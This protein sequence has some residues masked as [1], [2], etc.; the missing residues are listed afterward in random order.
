MRLLSY[1]YG[2][3][4]AESVPTAIEDVKPSQTELSSSESEPSSES[5]NSPAP[6]QSPV[7][8]PTSI[9][10]PLVSTR[11]AISSPNLTRTFSS[12]STPGKKRRFSFRPF[13]TASVHPDGEKHILSTIEE[14]D[15]REQASAAFAKRF[16]KPLS[17]NSDKRAKESAVVVRNLILGPNTAAPK[18]TASVARP[19]LNKIKSQLIQPKA[20]N[21]LIA[22]L[23]AMPVGST[24][25]QNGSKI[26]Y[27]TQPIHAVC[28]E[29]TEEEEHSLYFA[30]LD[31]DTQSVPVM[32]SSPSSMDKLANL[33]NDM[34][35]VSLVTS[36]DLG[37][38]Q[39]GNGPGLLAGAVPTAETVINGI[40]QITPQ[41]LA[42]G[43]A[44]GKAILPDHAGKSSLC[45]LNVSLTIQ[46]GVHPPTDRISVLTCQYGSQISYHF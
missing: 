37:L 18:V 2:S 16:T 6:S 26:A 5:S 28:L 3:P 32:A 44:T 23:R 19:Q 40:Q 30:H 15:K 35:I 43:F 7:V 38:G 25:S 9:P 1:L 42:L 36:P 46:T 11:F 8:P 39:P 29:H 13:N 24:D 14:H 4:K 12:T 33:F 45:V 20:A 22:Q 31:Q 10:E 21:K 27:A 34:R 17:S 41:L